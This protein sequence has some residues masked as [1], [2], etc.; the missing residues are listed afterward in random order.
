MAAALACTPVLSPAKWNMLTANNHYTTQPALAH[1]PPLL[2]IDPKLAGE[3][4]HTNDWRA[5][6]AHQV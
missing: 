6:F 1:I 4:S 5:E 2:A 3:V